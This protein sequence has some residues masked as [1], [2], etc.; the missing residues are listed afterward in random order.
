MQAL[1][2]TIRSLGVRDARIFAEAF[3]PAALERQ[4]DTRTHLVAV[5]E[6]AE[7]TVVILTESKVEQRWSAG[8]GTLLETA[9]AHGLTPNFSCRNG[10][11]GSCATKIK[12]GS[13]TYRTQPSATHATDEA[14]ICCAVPAKGTDVLELIL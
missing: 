6:E 4:P 7:E 13:I 9:E 8:E 14:L 11:C 12:S 3:G 1:Y 5:I 2:D 10:V